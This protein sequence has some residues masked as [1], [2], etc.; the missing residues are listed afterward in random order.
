MAINKKNGVK[1]VKN[2]KKAKIASVPEKKVEN[3]TVSENNVKMD[4]KKE[5]EG[6]L[7]LEFQIRFDKFAFFI[8]DAFKAFSDEGKRPALSDCEKMLGMAFDC[9]NTA[10][11]LEK[12]ENPLII[13]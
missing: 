5:R 7:E 2:G 9:R 12:I 10:R 1:T 3:I 4:A 8:S 6:K 13:A 11:K